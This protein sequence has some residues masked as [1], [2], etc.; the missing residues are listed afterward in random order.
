MNK[1]KLFTGNNPNI[2]P[3]EIRYY[4]KNH[5]TKKANDCLIYI[6]QNEGMSKK[7]CLDNIILWFYSYYM[8]V[9]LKENNVRR[10][11]NKLLPRNVPKVLPSPVVRFLRKKAVQKGIGSYPTI[12]RR[13]L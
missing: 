4:R 11:V 13:G 6:A 7:K 2:Q 1:A 10:M 12:V 3:G 9:A 5:I 8:G